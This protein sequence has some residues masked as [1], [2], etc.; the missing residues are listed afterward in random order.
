MAA[1]N[2]SQEPLQQYLSYK[3]LI[4]FVS[5]DLKALFHTT[6]MNQ[7]LTAKEKQSLDL[8]LSNYCAMTKKIL[9]NIYNYHT[10]N[11]TE[12]TQNF[13]A[14]LEDSDTCNND[15][16]FCKAKL[17]IA[18]SLIEQHELL[19][20]RMAYIEKI[21]E[22]FLEKQ[23]KEF[24][25]CRLFYVLE[26]LKQNLELLAHPEFAGYQTKK[27]MKQQFSL[28]NTAINTLLHYQDRPSTY[29]FKLRKINR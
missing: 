2:F 10:A 21:L 23:A 28:F 13:I 15:F 9:T 18:S 19:L 4:Q 8:E 22:D 5:K 3:E 7:T 27:A 17:H 11:A 16:H 12:E 6:Q 14:F 25:S 24:L 1:V 29:A 20:G 26:E